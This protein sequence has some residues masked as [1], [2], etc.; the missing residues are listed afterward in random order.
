MTFSH[1][2]H[3]QLW[4]GKQMNPGPTVTSDMIEIE[5][6]LQKVRQ[7]N[8]ECI[9]LKTHDITKTTENKTTPMVNV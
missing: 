5:T 4:I 6:Y 3:V 8:F 2:T 9:L 7:V 1:S